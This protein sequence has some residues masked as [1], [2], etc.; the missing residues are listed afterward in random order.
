MQSDVELL[1]AW[2]DGD[3]QA[4]EELFERH[5]SALYRFF[6]N[7]VGG[8]CQELVQRTL[9]AAVEKR[10]AFRAASSFRTF[11]FGIARFELLRFFDRQGRLGRETELGE[12]SIHDLDPSPSRIIAAHEEERLLLEAL[13]RLPIDLQIAVEL[14]Y[15]EKLPTDEIAEVLGIPRGT[16]KSRLRRAR[17]RLQAALEVL[18]D[19]EDA[20]RSTV[21]NLESWAVGLRALLE[22]STDA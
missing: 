9:L 1:E 12:R 4:G 3:S 14:H 18:A 17:E 20:L 5:F 21:A 19:D 15:W 22:K 13:R 11:L 2:R 7:K 6:R 16:V 8:E 10:D